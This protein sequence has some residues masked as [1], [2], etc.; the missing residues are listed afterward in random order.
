MPFLSDYPDYFKVASWPGNEI[1]PA[2]K[3]LGI[4]DGDLYHTLSYCDVKNFTDCIHCPVLMGFGLQ[5]DIFR[6]VL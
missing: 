6:Q 2:A 3:R 5:D 1:L 4:S